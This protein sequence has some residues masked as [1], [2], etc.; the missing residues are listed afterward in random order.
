MNYGGKVFGYIR[1]WSNAVDEQ[2]KIVTEAGVNLF[3]KHL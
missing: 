3:S 2:I 1:S